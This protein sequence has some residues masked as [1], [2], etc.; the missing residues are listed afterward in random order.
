M[1]T[2]RN[3]SFRPNVECL[4]GRDLPAAHL[5][6]SLSGGVL[7]IEG[8]T[9]ADR[10]VVRQAGGRV[11][12]DH[13]VIQVRGHG[14][15][16]S[17]SAAVVK[18]VEVRGLGGDDRIL[19]DTLHIPTEVWAGAGNDLVRGGAGHDK[20]HGG[21]GNDRLFSGAGNDLLDGGAGND[22]LDGGA[23]NDRLLGGAGN[24]ILVGGAGND[25]LLGGAGDDRL[26]GG[27]GND[28]LYGGT[29]KDV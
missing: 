8:T 4:E 16:R 15:A 18:K 7:R 12:V 22:R 25:V 11:S 23:G 9:H 17:V 5:T 2:G 10:I 21:A 14:Q 27:A 13:A 29:G 3:H 19:L 1:G 26:D 6:A 24:D 20:I 28:R